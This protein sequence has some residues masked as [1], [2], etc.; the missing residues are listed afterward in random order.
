MGWE[1]GDLSAWL[2]C[3]MDGT[4]SQESM[5]VTLN[6]QHFSESTADVGDGARW[7]HFGMAVLGTGSPRGLQTIHPLGLSFQ[8]GIL[9]CG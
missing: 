3:S 1:L 6:T 4:L 9:C 7:G 8:T 2:P 5:A